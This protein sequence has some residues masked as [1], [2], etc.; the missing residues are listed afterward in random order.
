MTIFVTWQLIVT[1]D[2][3]RNSCD[4]FLLS[5]RVG[6]W[7]D[8]TLFCPILGSLGT[9][10]ILSYFVWR[11]ETQFHLNTDC[12]LL[13]FVWK[14]TLFCCM[15]VLI[16]SS[17][18][19]SSC[20]PPLAVTN[21]SSVH[22][23][24]QWN[25]TCTTG[26]WRQSN[27]KYEIVQS[28]S[29]VQAEC[30]QSASPFLLQV[31]VDRQQ[32]LLCAKFAQFLAQF[33][34]GDHSSTARSLTQPTAGCDQYELCACTLHTVHIAETPF[35]CRCDMCVLTG[36]SSSGGGSSCAPAAE[37][38]GAAASLFKLLVQL[39]VLKQLKCTLPGGY[40]L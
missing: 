12:C 21:M 25:S 38:A 6:V 31:C 3:I 17:R 37:E 7:S 29:R 32:Q 11:R 33:L 36:S 40:P 20:V 2:S 39:N 16:G 26:A 22:A 4:V 23:E 35:C 14:Q 8:N 15:L 1:L 18:S 34:D 30:K 13:Q 10:H 19:S 24:W 27:W 28:T 9:K 5:L